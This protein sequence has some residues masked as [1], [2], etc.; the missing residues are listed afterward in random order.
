MEDGPIG[1]RGVGACHGE[2]ES[3][4]HYMPE[5]PDALD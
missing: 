1:L 4:G 3:K 5:Y 2:S